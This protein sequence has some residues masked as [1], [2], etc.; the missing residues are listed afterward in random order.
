MIMQETA[1]DIEYVIRGGGGVKI[2]CFKCNLVAHAPLSSMLT[3]EKFP[4][5]LLRII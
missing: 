1:L 3:L 5:G 2:N 4:Y